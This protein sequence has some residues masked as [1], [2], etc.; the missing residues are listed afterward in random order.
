MD[1][2]SSPNHG[3]IIHRQQLPARGVSKAPATARIGAGITGQG[4]GQGNGQ[5]VTGATGPPQARPCYA[6]RQ[7]R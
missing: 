2:R 3:T 1:E 6:G 5:G 7:V 4:N